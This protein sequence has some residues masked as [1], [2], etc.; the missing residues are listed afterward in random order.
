MAEGGIWIILAIIVLLALPFIIRPLLGAV[1][2][3]L[4]ALSMGVFA[5]LDEFYSARLLPA[6]PWVM[7]MFWGALIGASLAFWTVAPIFGLRKQRPLIGIAPL[8][9]MVLVGLIRMSLG[10]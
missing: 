8:I 3:S 5:L 9:L 7:W 6:A 10:H 4:V 2:A 1:Y